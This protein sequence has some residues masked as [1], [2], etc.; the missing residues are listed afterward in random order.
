MRARAN[1]C[2]TLGRTG[3]GK[4]MMFPLMFPFMFLPHFG[5]ALMVVAIVGIV[6]WYKSRERELQFHQDMR[7]REMEHQRKMK[8]LEVELEKAK[9]LQLTGNRA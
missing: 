1:A 2:C 3:G 5:G 4:L 7:A 8:E 9:A 6:I